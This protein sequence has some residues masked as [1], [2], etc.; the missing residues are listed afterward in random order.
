MAFSILTDMWNHLYSK[1]LE[2]FQSLQE[3]TSYPLAST[4]F[5]SIHP[6]LNNH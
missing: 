6:D 4:M 2:Y 5:C 1:F 3:E